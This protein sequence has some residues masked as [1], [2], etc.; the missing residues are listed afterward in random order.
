MSAMIL[1]VE[2]FRSPGELPKTLRELQERTKDIQHSNETRVN[3]A[4]VSEIEDLCNSLHRLVDKLPPSL[5][6]EP[7]VQKPGA[8]STRGAVALVHFSNRHNPRSST[9]KDYECSRATVMELWDFGYS[10]AQKSVANRNGVKPPIWEMACASTTCPR[11]TSDYRSRY[12][13]HATW[14]KPT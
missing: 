7:D 2:V 9:L 12:K 3:T 10:D 11:N 4:R 13:E 5:Q 6:T 8:V 14:P 1:Q